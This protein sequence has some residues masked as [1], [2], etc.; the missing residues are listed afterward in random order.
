MCPIQF[1]F[2]LVSMDLP[3]DMFEITIIFCCVISYCPRLLVFSHI[4]KFPYNI[5]MSKSMF[6]IEV[7]QHDT[8]QPSEIFLLFSNISHFVKYNVYRLPN[9]CTQKSV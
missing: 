9:C 2:L 3:N 8:K 1:H 6:M 7:E 4:I 5:S